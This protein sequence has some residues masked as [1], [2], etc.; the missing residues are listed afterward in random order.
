MRA[1][2][3]VRIDTAAG[4][5]VVALDEQRAPKT[6][7]N[8]LRY[9]DS[10]RYTGG[11]FHRTVKTSPDN[12]P[13]KLVK[14]NVIQAQPLPGSGGF[15]PI[16]LERTSVTGLHHEDGTISRARTGPDSAQ[17]QF[18]ICIGPQPELDFGG[19]RNADQQGLA[20]FGKV[21]EG[22]EVARKIQMSSAV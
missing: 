16:P 11:Q 15:D 12:Q 18:F 3:R 1:E 5:I 9:V 13:K 19:K 6:V 20:A 2:T 17:G 10:Q 4:T 14:I 8:F 7:A 22:M 21:V